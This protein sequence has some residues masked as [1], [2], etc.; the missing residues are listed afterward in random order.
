MKNEIT[1]DDILYYE[2]IKKIIN[3]NI[4]EYVKINKDDIPYS[5]DEYSIDSH[6]I[7]TNNNTIIIYL[8]DIDYG[9]E[10]SIIKDIDDFVKF[11]NNP[12]AY[13]NDL[14]I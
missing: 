10:E 8:I 1:K 2:N 12:D 9:N 11:I 7:N 6:Y 4:D 3:Y 14:K 5:I 13:K